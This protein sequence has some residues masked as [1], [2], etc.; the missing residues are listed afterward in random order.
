MNETLIFNSPQ[1]GRVRTLGNSESPLF[2]LADVCKCLGLSASHVRERLTKDVVSTDTLLTAGGKQRMLFINEDGLY[3]VILD[4]RKPEAK[5]FRKWIT[6]EVLP[7]IRKTGGYIPVAETDDEKEIL[8]KAVGIYERTVKALRE[9]LAYTEVH[10]QQLYDC[11]E[12]LEEEKEQLTKKVE[13]AAPLVKYAK[14]VLQAKDTITLTLAA[15]R[16]GL[17]S[18]YV[19]TEW[20]SRR[21][22]LYWDRNST[23]SWLPYSAYSDNG[24]FT[25]RTTT[26]VADGEL[27]TR[28]YLV[29]TQEGFKFLAEKLEKD[30]KKGKF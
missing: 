23:F 27:R 22:V 12:R 13:A 9:R 10:A 28:S 4:S 11:T 6:S 16:L 8:T 17:R 18:V 7:A 1:F 24:Y 25:F 15:K 30:K 29:V 2:C 21:K 26:F 20:L 14:D 5:A 3:D 19:L